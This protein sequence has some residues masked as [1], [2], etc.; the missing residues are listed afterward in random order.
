[1]GKGFDKFA[2]A[3]AE[4][5]S[6]EFDKILEHVRSVCDD[7]YDAMLAQEHKTW[8]RAWEYIT[9]KARK[10]AEDAIKNRAQGA[11]M[12][13]SMV[14]DPMVYGWFDEYVGLDDKAE[15][16][17]REKEKA[18]QEER[19]RKARENAPA[20]SPAPFKPAKKKDDGQMFLDFGDDDGNDSDDNDD[21]NDGEEEE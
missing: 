4:K 5:K 2:K 14:D 10:R 6:V 16:E 7:E 21:E 3:I 11:Q 12:V 15:C 20:P 1:M 13:C 8:D 9:E 18:E 19:M 17:K